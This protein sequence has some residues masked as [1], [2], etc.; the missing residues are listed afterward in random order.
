MLRLLFRC[1]FL[2]NFLFSCDSQENKIIVETYPSRLPIKIRI[3]QKYPDSTLIGLLV[4]QEFELNNQFNSALKISHSYFSLDG[5]NIDSGPIYDFKSDSLTYGPN[6]IRLAKNEKKKFKLYSVYRTFLRDSEKDK[7]LKT[8]QLAQ[9]KY[10]NKIF[11]TGNLQNLKELLNNKIPDSL[12]GYIHL[13][14]TNPK[15]EQ[16]DYLNIP[17]EF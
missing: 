10:G 6:K 3:I 14:Y 7:I 11:D 9:N 4:P 13:N 12:K 5:G 15:T 16:F 2:F 17:V 1:V 8:A